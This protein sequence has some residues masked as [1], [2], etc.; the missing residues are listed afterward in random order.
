VLHVR[1]PLQDQIRERKYLIGDS[2][3]A[4]PSAR[5]GPIR[6]AI[7]LPLRGPFELDPFEHERQIP[8]RNLDVDD[9][10]VGLASEPE[11]AGLETLFSGSKIHFGPRRESESDGPVD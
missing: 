6:S 4:H 9:T 7:A 2:T 1:R 11:G 8:G 10:A 5:H 3:T